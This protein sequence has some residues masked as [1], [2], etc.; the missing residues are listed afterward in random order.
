MRI[1]QLSYSATGEKRFG[2]RKEKYRTK[3]IIEEDKPKK[4]Y[5]ILVIFQRRKCSKGA[6]FWQT[7][8]HFGK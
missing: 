7:A 6:R 3:W 8:I 5:S 4:I 1:K 2:Y